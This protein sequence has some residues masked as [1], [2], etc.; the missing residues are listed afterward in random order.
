VFTAGIYQIVITSSSASGV[1]SI[2]VVPADFYA[3]SGASAFWAWNPTVGGSGTPAVCQSSNSPLSQ[4]VSFVFTVP[5]TGLYDINVVFANFTASSNSFVATLYKVGNV[6]F[7][8][9]GNASVGVDLCGCSNCAANWVNTIGDDS[10][11]RYTPSSGGAGVFPSISL[12]ASVNYTIVFQ[13]TSSTNY[14]PFGVLTRPTIYGNLGQNTNYLSPDLST[15]NSGSGCSPRSS[16]ANWRAFVFTAQFPTYVVDTG[17]TSVGFDSES[18]LYIGNNAGS[19]D[20]TTPP[21][22]CNGFLQCV[23]TGDIGPLSTN[24]FVPGQNYTI[25]VTTYSTGNAPNGTFTLFIFSGQQIGPVSVLTS[26]VAGGTTGAAGGTTGF[27]S[28]TTAAPVAT[29]GF[30]SATT[31]APRVTT[32][33]PAT[34]GHTSEASFVFPSLIFAM[35]ASWFLM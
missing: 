15:Y 28:A 21:N 27:S 10:A 14:G 23:D 3:N 22:T 25:V 5:S 8:G 29:T 18:D 11:T 31:A 6:A 12:S 13:T 32:G 30:S 19:V 2:H 17:P 7:I 26:G 1:F 34:T 20:Q 9:T 16:A 33:N 35:I 4:Y 24:G